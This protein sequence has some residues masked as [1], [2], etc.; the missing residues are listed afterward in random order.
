M[1]EAGR[2]YCSVESSARRKN[3]RDEKEIGIINTYLNAAEPSKKLRRSVRQVTSDFRIRAKDQ[4]FDSRKPLGNRARRYNE[5]VKRFRNN[6]LFYKNRKQV[7]RGLENTESKDGTLSTKE[8]IHKF[9]SD[10]W[11][12]DTPHDDS[13]FLIPE[14]KA[15][16]PKHNYWWKYCTSTH[17][18]IASLFQRGLTDPTTISKDLT[19]GITHLLPKGDISQDPKLYRPIAC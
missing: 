7:F 16:T 17:S 11:S 6:K 14:V 5:R 18:T 4:S 13:V 2:Y 10:I 3:R 19:L 8:T 1:Q 12:D 9:R 15:K